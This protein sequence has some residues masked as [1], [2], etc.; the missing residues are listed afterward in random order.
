MK[1]FPDGFLWGAATAAYQVE[2][3]IEN[4]DWAEAAREGKVPAAGSACDHYN[5]FEEDLD[6]AKSLNF[7]T[8]RFS[9]EWSRIEPEEGK[10]DEN[11]LAHYQKVVD[12]CRARGIE[13]FITLWHFTLPEWF[14]ESGSFNR[15][16]APE[17]FARYTQKV[18]SALKNVTFFTTMNEPMVWISEGSVKG[19]WPPFRSNP[20]AIYFGLPQKLM[21]AHTRAYKEIHAAC[22]D[23]EVGLTKHVIAFEGKGIL[24][25]VFASIS[26]Y[27]WNTRFF[28]SISKNTDFV[29]LNY[30]F[31]AKFWQKTKDAKKSDLGWELSPKGLYLALKE[32]GKCGKPIYITEHGLADEKDVHRAWYI[33]ESL[34]SVHKAIEEGIDVKGYSHWSLLDN[35]EWAEGFPPRFGLVAIDYENNQQ[36]TVRESAKVYAEV[37]KNNALE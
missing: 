36:R 6:I 1:K 27:V 26:N 21:K 33:L 14:S 16:D 5:R 18:A 4:N 7:T 22:P 8:Y 34:A 29:G 2:G 24:G 31:H 37:C 28:N 10:F 30:Y 19:K 13:P 35:F 3:G 20:L 15:K 12:A 23:A 32:A 11:E 25:K 9:I 17:V